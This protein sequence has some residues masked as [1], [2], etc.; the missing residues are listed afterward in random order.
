MVVD[1]DQLPADSGTETPADSDK[2]QPMDPDKEEPAGSDAEQPASSDTREPKD[3]DEYAAK[4]SHTHKYTIKKNTVLPTCTEQGYTVYQ[5]KGYDT[6]KVSWSGISTVHHDCSE[7]TKKDYTAMLPHTKG[8]EVTDKR[9]EP[10]CTEDGSSTYVCTVCGNE[11]QETLK[12]TGHTKG[13]EIVEKRVEPTCSE[14]G[15][16]TYVC[17]VCEKEFTEPLEKLPHTWSEEYKDDDK[18]GCQEQ[19]ESQYCT[20]CGARN[21]ESRHLSDAVRKNHKFTHY[22]V[23]GSF[24]L[25]GQTIIT[26]L[27]AYCDYGCGEKDVIKTEGTGRRGRGRPGQQG[28]TGCHGGQP[29]QRCPGRGHPAAEGKRQVR[30]AAAD[31]IRR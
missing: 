25:A 23:T 8:E 15:S 9:V 16:A 10:T 24:E 17:S 19:T 5:C 18:P 30:Q 22:E 28:R 13:T 26:E 12:A 1:P 27:T 31:Q 14:E 21:P 7:T 11:F 20:V 4:A 3:A 2:E 29:G 6:I